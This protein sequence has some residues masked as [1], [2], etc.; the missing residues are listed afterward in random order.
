[1]SNWVKHH[2]KGGMGPDRRPLVTIRSQAVA[3]NAQFVKQANLDQ[4]SRVS[5]FVDS[6]S[7]KLG[8]QFHSDTGDRGSYTITADGGS[9]GK[10]KG[11]RAVQTSALMNENPWLRAVGMSGI[12]VARRF[13]PVWDAVEGL[14]V[15]SVCPAFETRVSSGSEIPSTARGIYRYRRD[16]EIVYIGRGVIHSRLTSPERE[17]WEFDVIEYSLVESEADQIKWEAFW[18]DRFVEE[19]DRL[20]LYNKIRGS[21]KT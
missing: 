21:T 11:G 18:L 17:Q 14:W 2:R 19:N 1:M 3:F 15:I 7:F 20:P 5:F 8:V 4:Y 12:S 13:E 16:D 6:E 10:R 9:R